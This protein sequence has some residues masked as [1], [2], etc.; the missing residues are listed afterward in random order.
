MSA[1]DE[2]VATETFRD[3]SPLLNPGAIAV[4]GASKRSGSAG[5]LVLQN[6]RHL[7][8]SGQVYAV[9]PRHDEVLG[10]PCYPHLHSLPGPVDSVAILLGADKALAILEQAA[11]IG[12]P[13]AWV[14]A[15]GFAEAGPEGEAREAELVRI[16]EENGLMVCGPN[17]IGVA[18]LVAGSATYSVALSP[19]T[20]AGR[21][22]A[23]VQSGAICLGL[24]NSARFGFRTLISSGNEAV[25]DSAD[26]IGHLAGDPHTDVIV[27]FLEGIGS[28]EKFIAAAEAAAEAGKPILAVKV[29]RSEM[30]RRTV[31][32]HTGSLAGSDRVVDAAF[33]RLGVMR[34]DTLDELMEAAELFATCPVPEGEGVGLLS[35]SG[36]QIGL[37]ADLAEDMGL[38]FPDFS[39]EAKR[40]LKQILPPFSPIANPLDAW[41]SGDLEATYPACVDVVSWEKD[42]DL[43]AVSRGTPEGVAEREIEQSLAVADA[44]VEAAEETGKPVLLFSNFCAGFQP[45]VKRR[46]DEGGV[47]YLQGTRETLRAIQ[48]FVDYGSFLHRERKEAEVVSTSPP[49]LARWRERLQGMTGSLSEIEARRLLVDYGIPAPRER[50]ARTADEAAEAA[51]SIGY[52]VVLKV[53][54]PNIQH[55]TEIGGVRV[56]LADALAVRSAF[57]EVMEVARERHPDADIEGALIQEMVGGDAVEVIVGVLRDAD[58]GPVVV[59]GSGG[60]LVE[61]FEDSSLRLP[62]LSRSDARGM[63]EENQATR[64]LEGF[65]GKPPA[66]V[67]ALVDALVRVSRLAVDLGDH[68]AALDIN[69]LMVLPEGKGVRAVDALVEVGQPR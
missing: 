63:I 8:Y 43:L 52:P 44:A 64:L 55:K 27:A 28:P 4:V 2:T 47:P 18:D 42:V 3:L 16:A 26:Y 31:Q 69:P 59:F 62:P 38:T 41:G 32:A 33:R 19:K 9:H 58:F 65:R 29:G 56:G 5:R 60:V 21:V 25:L 37:I 51:R 10:F 23:V 40:S 22:S 17:C 7:G 6:L 48:A 34:V 39:Q 20:H 15:A 54:S 53:L 1:S 67:E 50:A 49:E 14:L 66:D 45:E 24:A 61:L 35:L 57:G 68:I 11:E 46:L 12:A 36:G 30:A 13:A